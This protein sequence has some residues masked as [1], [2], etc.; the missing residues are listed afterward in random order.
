MQSPF[1]QRWKHNLGAGATVDLEAWDTEWS[2][3]P[4]G[5][6]SLS[7]STPRWGS[8]GCVI[9]VVKSCQGKDLQ[10]RE[11]S[12]LNIPLAAF[13]T[14]CR[15]VVRDLRHIPSYSSS[16]GGC[17]DWPTIRG[18]ALKALQ[19]WSWNIKKGGGGS[20]DHTMARFLAGCASP[21]AALWAHIRS[22][23]L[24]CAILHLYLRAKRPKNIWASKT[25]E[26]LHNVVN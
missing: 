3:A 8:M 26:V 16:S 5:L 15:A 24:K 23:R 21:E 7:E 6:W 17:A 10:L 9:N 2:R 19:G 20:V 4:S 22:V 25:E 14:L 1:I 18:K 11:C 13:A 12:D